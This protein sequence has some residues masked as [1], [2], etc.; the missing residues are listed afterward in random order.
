[1]V[2]KMPKQTEKNL[3]EERKK[4]EEARKNLKNLRKAQSTFN[5]KLAAESIKYL[6]EN[7]QY[8]TRADINEYSQIADM[9]GCT[10][11]VR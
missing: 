1:M 8:L 4:R 5:Y 2:K 3:I 10:P 7:E 9:M 6:Q 11:V